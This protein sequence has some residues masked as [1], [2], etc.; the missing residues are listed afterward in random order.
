MN[1][2]LFKLVHGVV[3]AVVSKRT[4]REDWCS[5]VVARIP[6]PPRPPPPAPPPH[7]CCRCLHVDVH[8]VPL[9]CSSPIF[10]LRLRS[11][12][13][14]FLP[15]NLISC[16]SFSDLP[17]LYPSPSLFVLCASSFFS[18]SSCLP[19]PLSPSVARGRRNAANHR[20]GS[21]QKSDRGV[22]F[23]QHGSISVGV[24]CTGT[25]GLFF[26]DHGDA[27]IVLTIVLCKG[28][29]VHSAV[30]LTVI[31]PVSRN[32]EVDGDVA[33][34]SVQDIIFN[35]NHS[36]VT[37]S[38][39]LR[40]SIRRDDGVQDCCGLAERRR[41]LI[42]W[43]SSCRCSWLFGPRFVLIC[44]GCF[45]RVSKEAAVSPSCFCVITPAEITS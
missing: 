17:Y 19:L 3:F 27:R 41:V 14:L 25:C 35:R 39:D 22:F 37:D 36:R 1:H 16:Y 26:V 40:D 44:A 5:F 32:T 13:H 23:D 10:V 18:S 7:A 11:L 43:R 2:A 42:K 29:R 9:L 12:S 45:S 38:V 33:W 28:G 30:G 8:V 6:F 31:S 21:R 15:L 24:N 20:E 34:I 4:F